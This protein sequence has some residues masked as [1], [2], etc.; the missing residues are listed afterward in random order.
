LLEQNSFEAIETL[1]AT[2]EAKDPY[3][4]GHSARVQRVAVA[5]GERLALSSARLETL[6][7]GGLFHDIGKI[8]VPA[9]ILLKPAA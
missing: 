4:A 8:G 3:T 9:A 5:L 6:R 7:Y 1:N 2:V